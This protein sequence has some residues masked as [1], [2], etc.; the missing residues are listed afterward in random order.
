LT[1]NQAGQLHQAYLGI[2]ENTGVQPHEQEAVDLLRDAGCRVED[3]SL[4]QIPQGLVEYATGVAPEEV[5]I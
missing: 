4:V 1:G 5:T 3:D 2:L